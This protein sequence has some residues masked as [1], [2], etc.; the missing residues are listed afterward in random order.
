MW[1]NKRGIAPMFVCV[2][3][4]FPT[5]KLQKNRP[6]QRKPQSSKQM[7]NP[8]KIGIL[9]GVEFFL[10]IVSLFDLQTYGM[11]F[12]LWPL[13]RFGVGFKFVFASVFF[14]ESLIGAQFPWFLKIKKS[15]YRCYMQKPMHL[16]FAKSIKKKCKSRQQKVVV[17]NGFC[18]S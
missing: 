7:Q 14:S 1:Q 5:N 8:T 2:T 11:V 4:I 16:D 10:L 17:V 18:W 15:K 9:F 6:N 12:I 13:H 3:Q